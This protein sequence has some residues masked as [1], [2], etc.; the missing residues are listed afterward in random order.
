MSPGFT[1]LFGWFTSLPL[2]SL[3]LAGALTNS[4]A[5][6]EEVAAAAKA[7]PQNSLAQMPVKEVTVFKDG[8]AFVMHAGTLPTDELGNVVLDYLPTPVLGTFWPY[9]TDKGVKLNSVTAGAHAVS[10]E[11]TA[12]DTRA[13][14]EANIG[15]RVIIRESG[16]VYHGRIAGIPQRDTAE[17]A[18]TSPP[19]TP[20][21]LPQKGSLILL[22]T[23]EG[24]RVVPID[25]IQEVTF[26]DEPKATGESEEFRNLLTMRFNWADQEPARSVDVGMAYLQRG[27]RWIPNYRVT[28]DGQG[29]AKVEL[30]ATLINELADLDNVTAN[31]VIGVPTFYF[32][33]T[34]DPIA[35]QQ[36]VAQLSA[37]FQEGGQQHLMLSNSLMT[38]SA[39]MGEYRTVHAAPPAAAAGASLGP[40]VGEGGAS[41]DL[42]VFTVQHL[43]LKKGER[44][45]LPVVSYELPYSD[46]YT[47]D[48]PYG[49]PAEVRH[50]FNQQQQGE[51]ARLLAA[52]KALHKLRLINK[53]Q[54]PLTT[55]PALIVKDDQVLAQAMM[56]YTARGATTDL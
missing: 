34:T 54:Y 32:K 31:L 15:A 27:I 39:R 41:E 19:N 35:L 33:D 4:A 10:V 21:Q 22:E 56:T 18:T 17:L 23:D 2:A 8:H 5:L 12:L 7:V 51:L 1:S 24:T 25:R 42:F 46:I 9:S 49:P 37:Y 28:I 50:E 55:A 38:Q 3:L 26:R 14:L 43:S 48:L 6:A 20:A 52:P 13:M 16:I 53:S 36:T 29:Q 47:L 40:E 44:M 11:R 45:V 30:Q